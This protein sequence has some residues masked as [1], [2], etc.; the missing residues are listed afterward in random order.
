MVMARA[1]DRGGRSGR[2][3]ANVLPAPGLQGQ[4]FGAA[5]DLVPDLDP[6]GVTQ[7]HLERRVDAF[8]IK[9]VPD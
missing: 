2:L 1:V 9:P 5:D 6:A 7:A 3:V 8:A 4:R